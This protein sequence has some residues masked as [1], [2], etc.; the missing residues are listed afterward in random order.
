M[1]YCIILAS[2]MIKNED[3]DATGL[4]LPLLGLPLSGEKIAH[5]EDSSQ[6]QTMIVTAE[7]MTCQL[8]R[9]YAHENV[10]T[11]QKQ[12]R[13]LGGSYRRG[14]I[15]TNSDSNV[16]AKDNQNQDSDQRRSPIDHGTIEGRYYAVIEILAHKEILIRTL[17]DELNTKQEELSNK[18]EE[19]RRKDTQVASLVAKLV[20]MSLEL[21]TAKAVQ[22][23][24]RLASRDQSTSS[25]NLRTPHKPSID[26]PPS[27]L[28]PMQTVK[29]DLAKPLSRRNTRSS[30]HTN[31][32]SKSDSAIPILKDDRPT[33]SMRQHKSCELSF[34]P[35]ARMQRI[36]TELAVSSPARRKQSKTRHDRRASV[37]SQSDS[38]IPKTIVFYSEKQ[39]ED[40][41]VISEH[42]PHEMLHDMVKDAIARREESKTKLMHSR[43]VNNRRATTH[44]QDANEHSPRP[45]L[46]RRSKLASSVRS[47]GEFL[48]SSFSKS[49]AAIKKPIEESQHG[50][51][52]CTETK[53]KEDH[54]VLTNDHLYLDGV[55]FPDQWEPC[56]GNKNQEWPEF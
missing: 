53:D 25:S 32:H 31:E 48:H 44:S 28:I 24:F 50:A 10:E 27:S 42:Q 34:F 30:R 18:D 9:A 35:E 16:D 29:T 5:N 55:I 13:D 2:G 38:A 12:P 26:R 11:V 21:A 20:Q 4:M 51:E 39:D 40:T 15:I 33:S 22:D 49:D 56:D 43:D 23:E 37:H 1:Q 52:K 14:D 19:L 47:F 3:V 6:Q 8:G 54:R 36:D 46:A 17:Q 41:T 7:D 45:V